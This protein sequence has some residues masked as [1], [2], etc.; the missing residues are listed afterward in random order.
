MQFDTI[1]LL[2]WTTVL[3]GV[4]H[5]LDVD[6]IAAITDITAAEP[7]KR[8]SL[9][10]SFGYV[11]GHGAVTFILGAIAYSIGMSLPSGF[12]VI[13]EKV[14]GST[15]VVLA[16]AVL[17]SA[18]RHRDGSKVLSRWRIF[19]KISAKITELLGCVKKHNHSPVSE[20][21]HAGEIGFWSS[22]VI[23]AIHG[24]GVES[25]T[26]LV[27]LGSA[28]ALQ[29][30]SAGFVVIFL[31]VFAMMAANMLLA[32]LLV[33]G[34]QSAKHRDKFFLLLSVASAIFGAYVGFKMLL[35]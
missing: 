1:T 14:V 13:M 33:A 16:A 6:H 22:V 2:I 9:L 30:S 12:E 32:F 15:L 35:C 5:S 19:S 4:R 23:G 24:I 8:R 10:S 3:L 27:F 21:K 7:D 25:P 11:T 31:F 28:A 18:I 34:F 17:Y 20:H 29:G 26:Q